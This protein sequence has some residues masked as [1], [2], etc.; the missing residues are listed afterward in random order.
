MLNIILVL[1]LY[2]FQLAQSAPPNIVVFLAD[3]LGWNDVSWHNDQ[4][5]MPHLGHLAKEGVI[6]DQHYSQAICTPTRG[7]LLT[8]R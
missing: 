8:G 4:V 7:A 6:L 2:F 3:D 5:L 1:I